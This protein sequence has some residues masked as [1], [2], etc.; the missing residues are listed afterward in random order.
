MQLY[1]I[2]LIYLLGGGASDRT[3]VGSI[4]VCDDETLLSSGRLNQLHVD[5]AV[6]GAG[7]APLEVG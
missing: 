7:G 5:C 2:D 3:P 6:G 4:N 1:R